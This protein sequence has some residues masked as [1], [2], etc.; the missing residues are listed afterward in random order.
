MVLS[1]RPLGIVFANK[2][3]S[4]MVGYTIRELTSLCPRETARLLHPRERRTVVAR[5]RARAEGRNVPRHYMVRLV[6]KDGTVRGVEVESRRVTHEGKPLIQ[7]TM[8]DRTSRETIEGRINMLL[9]AIEQID[10]G[11]A[12]ITMDGKVIYANRAFASMHGYRVRELAGKHLSVFHA[13]A[14]M[15]A[16][17]KA[18]GRIRR[19][20]YF[21]GEV[22]H[23]RR[24]G[25]CFPTLMQT[26]LIR[27]ADG[28]ATAMVGTC[29]DI[30]RLKKVSDELARSKREKTLILDSVEETIAYMDA[31]MRIVWANWAA[32]R[33][34]GTTPG[35]LIGK[36][37]HKALHGLAHPCPR[38]P[39]RLAMST[40]RAAWAD[41]AGSDGRFLVGAYPVKDEEGKVTGGVEV[42]L[43]LGTRYQ[44][45]EMD[46]LKSFSKMLIDLQEE[47]RRHIALELHDHV[48]Q[49]LTA[50]KL[51]LR[52]IERGLPGERAGGARD[53]K[54]VISLIDAA[55]ADIRDISRRLRP[56]SLD[57]LGLAPALKQ[58][59][60]SIAGNS[61]VTVA[62]DARGIHGRIDAR[63]EIA[64]YR[65]VQ[66]ALNNALK[67][68]G[69]TRIS[70]FLR[71]R[72]HL[73][74]LRVEDDG[75]GFAPLRANRMTGLGLTG[76]RERIEGVGG[77]FAVRSEAGEGTRID[78][79]VPLPASGGDAQHAGGRP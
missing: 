26:G 8:I 55:I 33:S 71:R 47:E 63:I 79:L 13:K 2:A 48:G 49:G 60:D 54:G 25:S 64:L 32:A 5:M 21:S 72:G 11:V 44:D 57:I 18:L 22:W 16:V 37:C 28:K 31:R 74:A 41:I 52:R 78:V 29:R 69:C 24:D 9:R 46:N 7:A 36:R 51:H 62:F 38:C 56:P 34:A 40:G 1:P 20:G 50:T 58:L 3:F 65:V 6:R 4:A 12:V 19:A 70:V 59:T 66:E 15:P 35:R 45:A 73:V 76:M 75:R 42:A 67:Y 43:K 14:Q 27:A 77:T 10:E 68:S 17:R 53:F 61:G 39:C 30:T 23:A